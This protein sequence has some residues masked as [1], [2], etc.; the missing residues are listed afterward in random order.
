MSVGSSSSM[1]GDLAHAPVD[2]GLGDA[3][4]AQREGEIVVDR[5]GVV[6]DRELEH[7]R[8]VALLPGVAS[9]TSRPSNR[10]RPSVGR[11]RPEIRLRSVVLPQPDG[12]SSA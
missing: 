11:S 10:M 3:A 4:V 6:D 8:D 12:P 7:L 2:L 1:R 9:V 5:H